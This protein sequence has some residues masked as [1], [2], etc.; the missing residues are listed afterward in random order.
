LAVKIVRQPKKIALIGAPTSAAGLRAGQERAAASLRAAGLVAR[1]T[2]AGFEVSDLGDSITQTFQPDDEHPRARNVAA[3][4]NLLSD[5]RPRIE[6]AVKS[7]ALPLI[8][9]GDCSVVLATIAAARR[10]YR[11]VDL[12]Y[13]DGD[14]DFN[15][16]ATTPSGCVD[17]MVISHVVGRGAPELV[18]FW[19]EP[20]LVRE[21]DVALFGFDRLDPPEEM[22][23]ARS[24]IRRFRAAD[25]RRAGPAAAAQS[26]IRQL[27]GGQHEFVLHFDTDVISG[28]EFPASNYAGSS[29]QGM[30]G[31]SLQDVREALR[32]F[33]REKNLAAFDVAAYNPELDGDG[34]GARALIELIVD[35]LRARLEAA[36]AVGTPAT[37]E[38]EPS[39][40]ALAAEP[41][42]THPSPVSA[43]QAVEA[44]SGL[45]EVETPAA[46]TTRSSQEATVVGEDVTENVDAAQGGA[47]ENTPDSPEQRKP[48]TPDL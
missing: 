37:A 28:N 32:V 12:V 43:T 18:R 26:A 29:G 44:P 8:V 20:P 45:A 16:P 2:E 36:E 11:H 22:A 7:G 41:P 47:A 24:P 10:Y 33:T 34:R 9:S 46:P 1:L 15:V 31:L 14:A 39:T 42:P 35:V 4:V 27:H 23:L 30:G 21:A 19:G 48:G 13:V 40:S 17:G 3:V 38:P 25:V 5:L 6:Q